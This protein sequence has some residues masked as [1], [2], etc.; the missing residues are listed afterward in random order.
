MGDLSLA[1]ADDSFLP[2]AWTDQACSSRSHPESAARTA[3]P[4]FSLFA[5]QA[6]APDGV[7]EQETAEVEEVGE[8]EVEEMH[9]EETIHPRIV[10]S[11]ERE[12]RLRESLYELRQMNEVFEGFLGALEAARG[13]NEVGVNVDF[14]DGS[15]SRRG[16]GRRRRCWISTR[17]C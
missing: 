1:D 11:A 6:S 3:K 7:E 2:P 12:D 17:R 5:P 13:H 14:T 4:R 15:G 16:C 9:D 10:T 8:E